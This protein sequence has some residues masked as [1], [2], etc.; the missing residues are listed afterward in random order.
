MQLMQVKY[1]T[2]LAIIKLLVD[3]YISI[4][5]CVEASL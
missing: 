2:K 4:S 3:T 1:Q 5:S